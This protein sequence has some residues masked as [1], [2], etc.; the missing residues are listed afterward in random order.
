MSEGVAGH[1]R[2][3]IQQGKAPQ[4]VAEGYKLTQ[5]QVYAAV[6]YYLHNKAE[7]DE[8]LKQGG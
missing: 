3:S 6:A 2:S 1:D 4:E 5:E 7:V 8:Y